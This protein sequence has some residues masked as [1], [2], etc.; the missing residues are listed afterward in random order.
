MKGFGY[1]FTLIASSYYYVLPLRCRIAFR[2]QKPPTHLSPLS[3]GCQVHTRRKFMFCLPC[4][5]D[6]P[7]GTPFP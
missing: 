1:A 3:A 2:L 7:P 4:T 6:N 5:Q